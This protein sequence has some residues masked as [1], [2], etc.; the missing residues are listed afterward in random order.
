MDLVQLLTSQLGVSN[1]QAK[2][3]TGLLLKL[4]QEKLGASDFSKVS[5]AVP[6]SQSYMQ[7]APEPGGLAGAI[8]M[9]ASSFGGNAGQLGNLAS[10]AG[11]FKDLGLSPEMISKFIPI[12]LSFVQAKGGDG[13]KRLLQQVLS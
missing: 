2:G 11:G 6:N 13:V 1:Q 8:G 9:F 10:L 12:V 4:A 7:A 3:G 5:G